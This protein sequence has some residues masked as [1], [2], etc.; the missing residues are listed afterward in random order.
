MSRLSSPIVIG[1]LGGS[2]TRIFAE[3]MQ[4]LGVHIGVDLNPQLDN[5]WFTLLFKRR[6][7]FR[8]MLRRRLSASAFDRCRLQLLTKAMTQ[9]PTNP[10]TIEKICGW[11]AYRDVRSHGH[12]SEQRG[13][14]PWADE[15]WRSMQVG[16]E[17][18]S[19]AWGWKE[20]NSHIYLPLLLRQFPNLRYVH[21]LRHGLDMAFSSNV[22]QMKL[23]GPAFGIDEPASKSLQPKSA[24]EFWLRANRRVMALG[25]KFPD[26][27]IL[28][29]FED[30]CRKPEQQ[31]RA[32]ASFAS[33]E[34]A[35]AQ[36]QQ[37]LGR[38]VCPDPLHRY[39]GRDLTLFEDAGSKLALFGYSV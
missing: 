10:S 36:L 1:G 30:L 16:S 24:F 14:G 13:V 9:S 12:D 17:P 8:G 6:R 33:V 4:T 18:R 25:E 29:R 11:L 39:P 15:R 5:L 35:P 19:G 23:W 32:L 21:V 31:I 34:V 22:M 28:V 37:L 7:A 3:V 27:I 26:Q 20:P 38:I 2:G